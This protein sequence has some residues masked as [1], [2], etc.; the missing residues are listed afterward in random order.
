MTEFYLDTEMLFYFTLNLSIVG[1]RDRKRAR[2]GEKR[3][4][5]ERARGGGGRRDGKERELGRGEGARR[6]G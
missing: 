1:I 6:R 3:G 4:S 5:E 2:E